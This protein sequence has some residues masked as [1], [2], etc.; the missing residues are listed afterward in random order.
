MKEHNADNAD[1]KPPGK[2]RLDRLLVEKGLAETRERA[3]ALVMAGKVSVEG[4]PRTRLTPGLQ[5]P[6]DAN[7]S[8][9][10]PPKYVSRGGEKLEHA[11][12]TFDIRTSGTVA[13]DV[14]ASTGGFTDCLIQEGARRVYAVDVGRGQLNQR[15]REDPRVTVIERV[16]ARYPYKLPETVDM[17]V[18]DVSFISA[19]LVI[20]PAAAHVKP[21]S[22]LLVLVKPQFEGR[23]EEV[24]K[25][26]IVRSPVVHARILARFFAWCASNRLRIRGLT[27]S[28]LAGADGNREFFAWIARDPEFGTDQSR[29]PSGFYS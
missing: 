29:R 6:A 19:R 3:R 17:A 26:G 14:G 8:V 5:V 20:P 28:P 24:G 13:L 4:S 16:N 27:T 12:A 15:L 1:V 18:I 10:A 22:P 2:K 21:G 11:L 9:D 7:I 25:G 23:R